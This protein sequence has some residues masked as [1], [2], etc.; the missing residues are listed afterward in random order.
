MAERKT[1][2]KLGDEEF[3]A[4]D[5]PIE[6]ATERWTELKLEDG[7]VLRIKVVIGAVTRVD[8]I[9]DADGNPLYVVKSGNALTLVSGPTEP[10]E[11]NKP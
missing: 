4:W 1:K 6:E 9:K 7:A 5:V 3:D 8:S 11:R 2:I 10:S